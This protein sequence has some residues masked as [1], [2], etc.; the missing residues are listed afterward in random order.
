MT[1]TE[2]QQRLL[3]LFEQSPIVIWND[4]DA[5]FADQIGGLE[6]PGV[7]F[8]SDT[9]GDRFFLKRAVNELTP[10]A[11]LLVYR[12]G[13]SN[14]G[15]NWLADVCAYAPSFSADA[16]SVML[17]ELGADDTPEMRAALREFFAYLRR[18]GAAGRVR[19]V[20]A[21]LRTPNDLAVAVM[22]AALG[23]GSPAGADRVMLTFVTAAQAG[24]A[25]APL[26]R[27]ERAGATSAFRQMLRDCLGFTGEAGRD[28]ELASHVL[29]ASLDGRA[30]DASQQNR[31]AYDL[32]RQWERLA[33]ADDGTRLGLWDAARAAEAAGHLDERLAAL[34]SPELVGA[35]PFPLVDEILVRRAAET[36]GHEGD[37]EEVAQLVELRRSGVWGGSFSACYEALLAALEMRRFQGAHRGGFARATAREAWDA[38][39]GEWHQ[40]DRA[41]RRFHEAYATL[42]LEG[43]PCEETVH[44]LSERLEG[45]YRR[46]FLRELSTAWETASA[47][48]LSQSGRFDGVPQQTGFYLSQVDG[49]IG[50]S[51]CVWVIISDAMRFEVGAELADR[52]ERETQGRVELS[53]MQAVFPSITKC[54]MAALLPHSRYRLGEA[55]TASGTGSTLAVTVDDMS[56]RGTEERGEVIRSFLG[57]YH[58]GVR[59]IALQASPFLKLSREERREA[60]GDA[61][62]VYLY[63]NRI[64][65]VGDEATTEDDVFRACAEAVREL[66]TLVGLLVREFRATD[67]I[68][69]ADHGFTYTYEALSETDKVPVSEIS[70]PVVE[71]GKRY[72]IG[73]TGMRSDSLLPVSLAGVSDGALSGLAPREL[74]R[75]KRA[76]GGENYVHGGVSLQELCVPVLRFHNF[77]AGSKGYEKRTRT[78]V[79]LVSEL[80]TITN[81]SFA[82]DVLQ[83]TPAVGKTLPASYELFVREHSGRKVTDA[84][85][86]I[87]D[88]A[89][90]DPTLRTCRVRLRVRET[91]A[92]RTGLPCQLVARDVTGGSKGEEAVL[93]ELTLQIAFTSAFESNW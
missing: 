52:L 88:R 50:R 90:A 30:D 58:P 46:W 54:G 4:P 82:F 44:E 18:R 40:M 33:M 66:G 74:I 89:D 87:A 27:L 17:D 38:Y 67:V 72:V 43:G 37:C 10:E 55:P 78:E 62:L 77:R 39:A 83:T 2:I 60:V 24:G 11:R 47:Q 20:A 14:E 61:S 63:H 73:H 75:I 81:L 21:S 41:Y 56:A 69:T 49:L 3:R 15:A 70:G 16:S 29:L 7:T 25:R 36:L 76:G 68:V 22:A 5:E 84:Q 59:G 53:S 48:E 85:T 34:Q 71:A 9:D 45:V 79:S 23:A 6:L 28:G 93:A 86:V 35:G 13:D 64:D 19:E 8:L 92:G 42:R 57:T 1:P 65:A 80:K 91:Y 12:T 32:V 31:R 51:R 26:D